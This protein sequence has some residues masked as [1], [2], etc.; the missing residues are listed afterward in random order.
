[1][2][3]AIANSDIILPEA[4]REVLPLMSP[5]NLT[6]DKKKEF[7][8]IEGNQYLRSTVSDL[9]LAVDDLIIPWSELVLKEKIGAGSF[10]TVHRADWH[11]SVCLVYAWFIN[12]LLL[13]RGG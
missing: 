13:L 7:Q 2:G 11:G 5:S 4:P 9:S 10:G 8:L 1:A 3:Q 6:A 12:N